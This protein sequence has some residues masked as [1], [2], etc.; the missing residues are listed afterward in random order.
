MSTP[1]A[2]ESG[3]RKAIPAVRIYV[4]HR[5]HVLMLH[6]VAPDPPEDFHAGKWNGL[7]GKSDED[8]SPLETAVRELQEESGLAFSLE[9]FTP[10]G[11]LQFPNFKPHKGE[12]WVAWVFAVDIAPETDPPQLGPCSEGNLHWIKDDAVLDL[13]LWPGDRLFCRRQTQSNCGHCIKFIFH[14]RG[15]VADGLTTQDAFLK[16]CDLSSKTLGRSHRIGC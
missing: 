9:P 16:S 12:D 15:D 8:E 3:K 14:I 6:R 2:F 5:G 7:G 1:N 10:L 4:R 13:N 11:V